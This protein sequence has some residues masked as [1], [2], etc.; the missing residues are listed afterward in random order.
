MHVRSASAATSAA[1]AASD[2]SDVLDDGPFAEPD[3]AGEGRCGTDGRH[4]AATP[5]PENSHR[6]SAE[7]ASDRRGRAERCLF[8]DLKG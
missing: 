4:A 1:G 3:G 6:S 5:S 2:G 7:R 8:M